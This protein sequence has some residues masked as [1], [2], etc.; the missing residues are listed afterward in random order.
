MRNEKETEN[1]TIETN[2]D[3]NTKPTAGSGKGAK[4]QSQPAKA[5]KDR[6]FSVKADGG[7]IETVYRAVAIEDCTSN[8]VLTAEHC[9]KMLSDSGVIFSDEFYYSESREA[10][11]KH[12]KDG[13]HET[14]EGLVDESEFLPEPPAE[15]DVPTEA[16]APKR[17]AKPKAQK[18]SAPEP[19]PVNAG[20]TVVN[21]T[22][23][24]FGDVED[25]NGVLIVVFVRKGKK[26]SE[27]LPLTKKWRK[28]TNEEHLE[29]T[30]QKRLAA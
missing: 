18:E 6:V 21:R 30:E 20:D 26:K 13:I 3:A 25:R 22:T 5:G 12:E 1:T 29:F 17:S 7:P 16:P 8:D 19:E 2:D 27:A 14:V 24:G 23:G 9:D 15:I 4:R 28:A 10:L 11:T